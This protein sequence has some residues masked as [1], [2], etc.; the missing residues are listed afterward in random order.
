M[1]LLL[2]L[3]PAPKKLHKGAKMQLNKFCMYAQYKLHV[4][5]YTQVNNNSPLE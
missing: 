5:F 1:L 3:D 2:N 4:L